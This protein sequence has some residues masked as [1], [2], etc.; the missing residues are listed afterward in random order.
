MKDLRSW[1]WVIGWF[2]PIRDTPPFFRLWNI[3]SISST[4]PESEKKR[5]IRK[6]E[7]CSKIHQCKYRSVISFEGLFTCYFTPPCLWNRH[8]FWRWW[9]VLFS[10]CSGE[11]V[12]LSLRYWLRHKIKIFSIIQI[13]LCIEFDV[14]LCMYI[15]LEDCVY[16]YSRVYSHRSWLFPVSERWMRWF[17]LRFS[18]TVTVWQQKHHSTIT[19]HGNMVILTADAACTLKQVHLYRFY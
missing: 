15:E 2:W 16:L 7:V 11:C 18:F 4:F 6:V 12:W 3:S 1:S 5:G 14:L 8:W 19:K 9:P 10:L 13:S 17:S